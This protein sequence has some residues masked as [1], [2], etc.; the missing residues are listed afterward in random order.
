MKDISS[1]MNYQVLYCFTSAL[2]D[3]FS[4]WPLDMVL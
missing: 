4:R 3:V 1:Y 2:H